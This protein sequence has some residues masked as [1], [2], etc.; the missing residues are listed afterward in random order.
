MSRSADAAEPDGAATADLRVLQRV[1][2]PVDR[3]LDVLKLY[4]EGE[5]ARGAEAFAAE[6]AVEAG[7]LSGL[8][9]NVGRRS[10]VVPV[11][12]R[13][14]FATYFNAFPAS[15]WRRWT[16]VEEVTLR[17]RLRGQ[18]TVIVYR[19]SA[20]GHIQRVD[21]I[22]IDSAEPREETVRLPLRPFIDGGWYWM[23]ILAGEED[24]VL[25][26]ADWC[27]D[28]SATGP[29]RQGR[30]SLGITTFNRPRFC[31]DQLVALGRAPEVL[32]VVDDIYV[33]DQGTQR[34][35]DDEDFAL[36]AEALG[37]RLRVIEQGNLGGS[38]GFSRA[39]DETVRAGKSDYVLL[40]D[41]DVVTETEGVLRAV[42]FGDF[43]RTPTIVG[44]HMFN[45]FVRSQLHAYGETIG[46]YRWW[47]E[48]APHTR[49][50]HDFAVPAS[51]VVA[52]NRR[53]KTSSGSLRE[54]KWLH[55]R[56]DVDYNGWWMC[57]IPTDVVRKVGLSMPMFIK[58]DDAEYCVRAG[59]AG[60]PTVSL[61]G[62]AAWHVPWQDKDDGIDWQAYFHERNRLVSALLH[63][64]YER[65]GNLLKESFI[66]SVKHALAMQYST[67][68]LMLSA[69]EDVL[70]GP[71]HMHDGLTTKL[72]EIL[73]FRADFPDARNRVSHEEF[74]QVRRRKPPRRGRGFK[75]PRG[76]ANVLA[77]AMVGTMKQLRPVD[78]TALD[79]PQAVVPHIDRHW[80]LLA[81]LDSALVSSADGTKVA[82]Y[83]RDPERF[84]T[85]LKRTSLLHARLSREWP[86]L[87]R[88]YRAAMAEV[89][90]PEA[91]RATFEASTPADSEDAR[92]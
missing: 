48:E 44:G 81:Q 76:T 16:T 21:S 34:V 55:R 58:W 67:A 54:T 23:D 49:R 31:V 60:F 62:M 79:N 56:V 25:E 77:S 11:G 53:A 46:R 14:S 45:L 59:E 65:G 74:P 72:P 29:V 20:K 30:V 86:A 18:A 80:S 33:V 38:G 8:A 10:V 92:G 17:V 75:P 73:A 39:M 40:L 71:E 12:R 3:D 61:P 84:R 51:P 50:E 15:Y 63:S 82:W 90:S 43:A 85:L 36:A 57:L 19:S 4:V 83:R 89:A 66:I 87:S 28:V 26:R 24:A 88:R 13:V 47:W 5:I 52:P 9:E 64:P 27:A 22:R 37:P 69:I 35:R 32:E 70:T 2:M 41:D 6:A 1:V 7:L 68:E 42:A 78:A 91:W